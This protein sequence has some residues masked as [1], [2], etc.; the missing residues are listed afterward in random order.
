MR[1]TCALLAL[2]LLLAVP[3][4]AQAALVTYDFS[5]TITSAQGMGQA[6]TGSFS[7]STDNILQ[8]FSGN[9]FS[10]IDYNS[11]ISSQITMGGNVYVNNLA[12]YI[13]EMRVVRVNI[14]PPELWGGTS[15]FSSATAYNRPSSPFYRETQSWQ[16][17]AYNYPGSKSDFLYTYLLQE[18]TGSGLNESFITLR[19][20]ID[21]FSERTQPTPLPAAVWLLGSGLVGLAGL[22]KRYMKS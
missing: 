11:K 4:L 13:D 6:Y 22:R 5:G 21:S 7:Y 10:V 9:G 14:D 18:Q 2:C 15:I 16:V 1:K 12:R 3:G 20:T 19:G 8:N 17:Q